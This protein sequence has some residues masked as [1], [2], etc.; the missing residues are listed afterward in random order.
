MK[1]RITIDTL[2]AG[3]VAAYRET[4]HEYQIQVEVDYENLLGKSGWGW[5]ARFGGYHLPKDNPLSH[6]EEEIMALLRVMHPHAKFLGEPHDW[7]DTWL[8]IWRWDATTGTGHALFY[9]EYDD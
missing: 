9:K 1:Q 6:V 2:R 5:D 8:K 7:F 4:I 3:Q